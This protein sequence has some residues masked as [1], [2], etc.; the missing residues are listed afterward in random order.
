MNE[1]HFFNIKWI[2]FPN[3]KHKRV[4]GC[5]LIGNVYVGASQD[6]RTRI[7]SHCAMVYST[8]KQQF[9]NYDKNDKNDYIF[10]RIIK[11]EPIEVTY[12]SDNVKDEYSMYKKYN[13]DIKTQTRFYK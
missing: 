3:L 13:I 9:K 5:Y 8:T 12:I 2:N 10:S 4:K 6:I 1:H 11:S 7:L